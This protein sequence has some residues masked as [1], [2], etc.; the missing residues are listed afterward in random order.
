MLISNHKFLLYQKEP[1]YN[2]SSNLAIVVLPLKENHQVVAINL[3]VIIMISK[4]IKK[5]IINYELQI[6]RNLCLL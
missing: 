6:K 3:Q 2:L 5:E 4:A 1:N